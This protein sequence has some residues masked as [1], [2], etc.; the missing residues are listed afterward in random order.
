MKAD[1]GKK[2]SEGGEEQAAPSQAE[3]DAM[4]TKYFSAN[5]S[6][7]PQSFRRWLSPGGENVGFAGLLT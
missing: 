5:P 6:T 7:A 3:S 2:A 4:A 1:D